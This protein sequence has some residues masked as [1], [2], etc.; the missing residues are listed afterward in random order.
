MTDNS[1]HPKQDADPAAVQS[2]SD[3]CADARKH[4]LEHG[5]SALRA[6]LDGDETAADRHLD[7][8]YKLAVLAKL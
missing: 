2:K 7:R 3:F 4:A 1:L 8:A 5:R 6:M